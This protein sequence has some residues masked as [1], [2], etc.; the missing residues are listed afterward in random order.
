FIAPALM[1]IGNIVGFSTA[2]IPD[3][4]MFSLTITG[5][6][7]LDQR[8]DGAGLVALFLAVIVRPDSIAFIG[9][10][11]A[12][13]WLFADRLSWKV[14]AAFAAALCAYLVIKSAG[15]HPGWWVHA[16]FSIY[17]Y[18]NTLEGFDPDFSLRIYAIGFVWNLVRGA[19]ENEWLG[20]LA[21][22]VLGWATMQRMGLRM[23]VRQTV[24]LSAM[25]VGTLAK[26]TVFPIHDTRF[27]IA[28]LFPA[29]LVMF[30]EARHLLVLKQTTQPG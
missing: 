17:R 21:L 18:E 16:W 27:Y 15:T 3:F 25:L 4:L 7:L 13:A 20:L 6:L 30:A 28:L 29:M 12:M 11:M 23:R 14:A 9:V 8:R 24:L 1:M 2:D 22:L 19:L 5:I 26:Y 10:L